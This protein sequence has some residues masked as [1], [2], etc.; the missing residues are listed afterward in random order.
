MFVEIEVFGGPIVKE[1][2]QSGFDMHLP[3]HFLWI[4]RKKNLW[5]SEDEVLLFLSEKEQVVLEEK[6]VES[7]D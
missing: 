3:F 6:M 7:F 1:D 4:S 2:L 5:R